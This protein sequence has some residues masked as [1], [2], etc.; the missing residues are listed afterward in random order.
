MVNQVKENI[1]QPEV[2][3]NLF[4]KNRELFES[5]FNEAFIR[6]LKILKQRSSGKY[7]LEYDKP[8]KKGLNPIL[9]TDFIVMI[10]ACI[11]SGFLIKIPAI[12]SI[13]LDNF[14]FYE[15]NAG[16]IVFL[17]LQSIFLLI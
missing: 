14:F 7:G 16:M 1:N 9:K 3:E 17:G 5:E 15:K 11:I 2:L 4:R 6:K 8:T 12:F 13:D 10:V